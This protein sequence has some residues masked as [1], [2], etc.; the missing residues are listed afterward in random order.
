M[1]VAVSEITAIIKNAFLEVDAAT[2]L[3]THLDLNELAE[4]TTNDIASKL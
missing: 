4:K 1:S 2:Y 3:G